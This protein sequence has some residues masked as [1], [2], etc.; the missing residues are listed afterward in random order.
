MAAS[1]IESH[2]RDICGIEVSDM[3]VSRVTDQK[4]LPIAK[5]W[6]QRPPEAVYT[7]VFLN[8]IHFHVISK[9]QIVKKAVYIAIGIPLNGRKNVLGMRIG[10]NKSAKSWATVPNDL[11]NRGLEDIFIAC[12][13]NLTGFSAAI[14]AFPKTE[15]QNCAIHQLRNPTRI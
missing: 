10:E 12:A 3:T 7:V 13:D 5:E 15:I 14:K 1:D 8:A 2:I 4:I 11:R 6:L 9:G